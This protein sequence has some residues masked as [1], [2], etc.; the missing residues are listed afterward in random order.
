[1]KAW[2][3]HPLE[4]Y[5]LLLCC[6]CTMACMLMGCNQQLL[7]DARLLLSSCV[8]EGLRNGSSNCMPAHYQQCQHIISNAS[9]HHT[10][11]T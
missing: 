5:V 8:L 7:T 2:H 1:M 3:V 10:T 4:G 6:G 9:T 11:V